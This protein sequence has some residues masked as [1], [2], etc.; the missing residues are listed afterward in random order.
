V[1]VNAPLVFDLA[2]RKK[3][4]EGQSSTVARG[5]LVTFEFE[6]FNQGSITAQNVVLTDYLPNSLALEDDNWFSTLPGQVATTVFGP[7]TPG[8]SVRLTLTARLSAN[9]TANATLTNRA[10]ISAAQTCSGA[11]R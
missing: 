8:Q 4:A 2:L 3:L 10:E 6:V 1:K 5:G 11:P 7:I 9:A